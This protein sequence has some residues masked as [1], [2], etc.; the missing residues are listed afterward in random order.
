MEM[1][2]SSVLEEKQIETDGVEEKEKHI[3]TDGTVIVPERFPFVLDAT[4]PV[5]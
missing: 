2:K 5:K 4:E 1:W 3:Q